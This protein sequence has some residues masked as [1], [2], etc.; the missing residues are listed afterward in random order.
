[1][2]MIATIA[3]TLISAIGSVTS[4]MAAQQQ[5]NYQAKVSEMNEKIAKQNAVRAIERSQI[6]QEDQDRETAA[7]LGEIVAAQ[8]ASGL[9]LTSRSSALTR[10]SAR[11]LGRRDALNIRQAG[12]IEA[13]NYKT[14]AV[15]F[16][17]D[18]QLRRMEGKSSLLAGF[19]GGIGS[20]IGGARQVMV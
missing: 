20:L 5:A 8:G 17:A 7:Q 13:Y 15:N 6:E 12:E 18:A 16:E 4:G 1:M 3:G 2:A 9:S 10:K 11:M 19:V 14:Q